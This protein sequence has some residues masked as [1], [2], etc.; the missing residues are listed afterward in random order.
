MALQNFVDYTTPA[1]DA[2]WLNGVDQAINGSGTTQGAALVPYTPPGT[3]AVATTVAAKLGQ[4]VSVMDFGADPTGVTDSSTAFQNAFN[5]SPFV[6]VPPANSGAQWLVHD[7]TIPGGCTVLAYGAQFKDQAGANWMFKLTGYSARLLG[8][9]VYTALNCSQAVVIVENGIVCELQGVRIYNCINGFRIQATGGSYT[10]HVQMVDCYVDTFTGIGFQAGPNCSETRAMNCYMDAGLVSGTGGLIP[11][12]ST[13]GFYLYGTGS[14]HA[15]GGHQFTQCQA[16]NTQ[17][18]WYLNNSNLVMLTGCTADDNSARGFAF[19]GT[20]NIVTMTGCY[21]GP[22]Y[23]G[24]WAGAT[25]VQLWVTGLTTIN[26]GTI[27]AGYGSNFYSSAVGG[28]NGYSNPGTPYD[29]QVASTADITVDAATWMASQGTAHVYNVASSASLGL[30]GARQLD[31]TSG[32]AVATTATVYLGPTGQIGFD[33]E[34]FWIAPFNC[35]VQ[36][37]FAQ[38]TA[39]PGTGTITITMDVNGTPSAL[40]SGA[41]TGN[42]FSTSVVNGTQ[43]AVAKGQYVTIKVQTA[44]ISNG[45]TFVNGYLLLLPQP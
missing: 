26:N 31:F 14:T 44:A 16:S 17:D 45:T 21:T 28:Y 35:V 29:I 27:V 15:Y 30:T 37:L 43:V 41:V 34:S 8:A 33:G 10:D 23:V 3:G 40:T 42:V 2:S 19:D 25:V 12:A 20:T 39:A 6:Y 38:F 22:A 11:R 4:F 7:V 13:T 9:Y 36:Q 5:S 24:L 1:V 32:T 18:G